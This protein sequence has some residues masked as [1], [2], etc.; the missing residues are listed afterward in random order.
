[1]KHAASRELYAYWQERRGTRPA[2]ERAEIEPG[3]IR[4][5]LSDAFILALDRNAGHPVRLAGTRVCALFDRELKGES[6]LALWGAGSKTIV[7]SLLE[8]LADECT[9]TVAGVTAQ[10]AGGE[11]IDLELLLLPL[12]TRRRSFARTIGVLAPLKVPLWL[13]ASP[14]GPLTLGG[15]RHVGAALEKRLL[16]R[17]MAPR[18]R[19]GLV[20]Y[21]G[22][23][24]TPLPKRE[25]D[26]PS[27]A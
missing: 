17:F 11:P 12:G 26:G 9:G 25:E 1:M 10:N 8:I 22:G 16:P 5:A 6:F 20:V 27:A 14:I 15:R 23:R 18:G 21:E 4:G 13:G 24:S 2:P 19:R 3:A 7:G